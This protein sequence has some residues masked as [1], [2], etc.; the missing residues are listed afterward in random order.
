ML[1]S[2]PRDVADTILDDLVELQI[3][4]PDASCEVNARRDARPGVAP[5]FEDFNEPEAR[6]EHAFAS[7][8]AWEPVEPREL[9]DREELAADQDETA[10]SREPEPESKS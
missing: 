10:V 1:H 5:A 2:G 7:E 6:F 4:G 8:R 9:P 3:E